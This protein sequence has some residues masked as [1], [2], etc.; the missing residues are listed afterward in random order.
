R[1]AADV[2]GPWVAKGTRVIPDLDDLGI[3][4]RGRGDRLQRVI[5][6]PRAF[7]IRRQAVNAFVFGQRFLIFLDV[8]EAGRLSLQREGQQLI[9]FGLEGV[10]W[11][12]A[13]RVRL[14]LVRRHSCIAGAREM[15]AVSLDPGIRPFIGRQFVAWFVVFPDR[16]RAQGVHMLA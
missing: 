3:G 6:Q 7:L 12:W 11:V 4:G 5:W 10:G 1:A 14:E 16:I 2:F 13:R 9:V 15:A 8:V